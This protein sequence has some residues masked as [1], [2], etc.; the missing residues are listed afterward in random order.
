MVTKPSLQLSPKV[1]KEIGCFGAGMW[2]V[3]EGVILAHPISVV[4]AV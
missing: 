4:V 2:R 1:R 3:A